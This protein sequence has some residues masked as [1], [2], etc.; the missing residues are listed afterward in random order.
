MHEKRKKE[1]VF[2]LGQ[3][4]TETNS[5]DFFSGFIDHL[6][7]TVPRQMKNKIEIE[8]KVW[9]FGGNERKGK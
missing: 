1:A 9:N 7:E 2:L 8:P 3:Y 6:D 4:V 5:N